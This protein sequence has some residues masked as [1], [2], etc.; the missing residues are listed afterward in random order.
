MSVSATQPKRVIAIDFDDVAAQTTLQT[1]KLFNHVFGYDLTKYRVPVRAAVDTDACGVI[2]VK[3]KMQQLA[4]ACPLPGHEREPVP[5]MVLAFQ[6]LKDLGYQLHIVTSRAD[7]H[8][9][10][11]TKWFEEA[12]VSVGPGKLIEDMWF[13]GGL[14]ASPEEAQ[15]LNKEMLEEWRLN[16]TKQSGGEKKLR[17]STT[18]L[19][20]AIGASILVDDQYGNFPP[21]LE[22]SDIHCL[23]FGDYAWNQNDIDFSDPADLLS[24]AE[25]QEQGLVLAKRDI[26]E[27]GRLKRVK[28]WKEVVEFVEKLEKATSRG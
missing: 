14:G 4:A 2:E 20:Q 25:R 11:L 13:T 16:Y 3:Q 8:R 19:C 23:L 5:G 1:M 12:G 7:S 28:D 15:E 26:K 27:G 18:Q 10:T 6:R 9:E 22:N 21:M 17:Q 24:H